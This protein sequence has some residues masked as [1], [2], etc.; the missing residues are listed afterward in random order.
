MLDINFIRENTEILKKAVLDKG[1]NLD[2]DKLLEVDQRRRELL[3]KVEDLRRQRN[4]AAEKRDVE[5]GREIKQQLSSLEEQ[6][7][8]EQEKFD[9]LMLLVPNIPSPDSPIGPNADSNVELSKWGEIPKFDFETKDH[10]KLGKLLDII[11]LDAGV[12]VSGFRGYYL[13]NEGALLHWAILN[14]A[15]D[16]ILKNGFKLLVPPSLVHEQV[17]IGSG[18]FPFAKDSIYQISNPG[19][20]ESGEDITNS[21]YLTGTSEPSLLAYYL[22]KTL[23]EEDLPIKVAALTQCYRSEVGDYGKDTRGLYRVHEFTKVEQVVICKNDLEESEQYFK[24]MQQLSEQILQDLEIPY[25]VIA[26]STGDM[27]AGKYRMNDI[28]AWMP[29]RDKYGETH[30]NSNLTDWQARR[31]KLKVKRKNGEDYFAYTLNNTVIASPRILIA[32]LE[33]HQQKDGSV[34]IPKALVPYTNFSV[35]SPK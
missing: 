1:I 3:V 32:L 30:S 14:F 10:V 6:L 12:K 17:L 25:H 33:N 13:K 28:E 11:D 8:G 27:G 16:R 23:S 18:H 24:Q 9:Q 2:V 20:L 29:G 5:K 34:K 4:Q 31:L 15:K 26:T 19:K 21:I 7:K 35:I 22:D